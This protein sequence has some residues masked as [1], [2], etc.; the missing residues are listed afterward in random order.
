MAKRS[1][2]RIDEEKCTGCGV[3]VPACAEGAIQI[4]DGKARLAADN[5]CDGL[6]ACLGDCPE[7]AITIEER[8]ADEY[9]EAAVAKR[10][11]R[12][13]A[14]DHGHMGGCPGS[15]VMTFERPAAAAVAAAGPQASEL[16]QWPV[17][18]HLVSPRA[19]YF[20]GADL[21]LA[22]DCTAF[23]MGD[24]HSG[25]L[26]GKALAIAC[27][28]LD[29]GQDAYLEKLVALVDEARVNTITV[30]V[31]EVPCCGGLQRLVE[32]ALSRA[33]R[34]VPL[35]RVLVSLQGEVIAEDWI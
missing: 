24:F 35:K 17:Q 20:Q 4:V 21:L 32:E 15:R 33:S 22:A 6:G 2:V 11:G 12:A 7:G 13:P 25:H 31:M 19:P 5:L 18:L 3:C 28:K 9:D 29:E 30:L 16:R 27:P 34:K 14:H 10:L 23:A 8:D 1:I 26:K